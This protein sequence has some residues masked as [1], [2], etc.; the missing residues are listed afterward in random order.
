MGL[1]WEGYQ[2]H[3][4][5]L[6]IIFP[7][8]A[9]IAVGLRFHARRLARQKLGA[10]D[11][12]IV[13]ALIFCYAWCVNIVVDSQLGNLGGHM[14]FT[15][16]GIPIMGENFALFRQT[17]YVSVVL[18]CPTLGLI[19]LSIAFLYKRIFASHMFQRVAWVVIAILI[20]WTVSNTLAGIFACWPI[21]AQWKTM[22]H[23]QCVNL[24][25]LYSSGVISN[26][27]IDVIVIIVP[28]YN[29][30][31]LQMPLKRKIGV[32]LI[33]LLGGFVIIAGIVRMVFLLE[34][35][36]ILKTPLWY[37]Y[38]YDISPA[39]LWT[40][41]ELNLGVICACL[42]L[43]RPV[44]SAFG[45][46]HRMKSLL[47]KIGAS[48]SSSTSRSSMPSFVK[49]SDDRSDSTPS[50]CSDASLRALKQQYDQD[51][52]LYSIEDETHAH[53]S[54]CGTGAV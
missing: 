25:A 9:T 11:W 34:T 21:Q 30:W 17:N 14:Q 28:V 23:S 7:I 35:Y 3:F 18:A 31:H 10:D 38:S 16:Q 22:S 12:L 20:A 13:A 45:M 48:L 50:E 15:P 36:S 2:P 29:V 32:C 39:I 52:A 53:H 6:S 41:V 26:T 49:K 24:R 51:I 42:P 47:S 27:I 43:M 44:W 19:K 37:D 46:D 4:F 5:I 1:A 40:I 54:R 33:F 8:L